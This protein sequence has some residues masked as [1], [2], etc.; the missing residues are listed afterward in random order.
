MILTLLSV[1]SFVGSWRF[2]ERQIVEGHNC[3]LSCY[4][5]EENEEVY[6]DSA[7]DAYDAKRDQMQI[8]V[9]LRCLVM[10]M[11]TTTM[12][13]I[14]I[15]MMM[16]VMMLLVVKN[17]HDRTPVTT[18]GLAASSFG[19]PHGVLVAIGGRR[20]SWSCCGCG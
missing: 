11:T 3:K 1:L 10:V 17:G 20:G 18:A 6:D 16:M 15:T 5:R 4:A 12:F 19:G 9:L 8:V 14:M 13:M 7:C 2:H